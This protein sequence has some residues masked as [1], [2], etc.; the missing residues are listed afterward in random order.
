MKLTN[1]IKTTRFKTTLWYSSIFLLL[2]IVIG[3]VIYFYVETSMSRHLDISLQKQVDLIYHFVSE[4]VVDLNDF[5]AD[6]IYSTS[7]ELVYDLIF[8]AVAFNPTNTFIQVRFKDKVVFK[9]ANLAQSE[10]NISPSNKDEIELFT[11]SDSLLS[12]HPIRAAYLNKNGYK[13]IAAFPIYLINETLGSLTDLYIIIAP[14]FFLLSLVGGALISFRALSRMDRIIKKTNEITAQNLNEIIEGGDFDD[15]YGRLV[16]T[17][18]KMVKRIKTSIDYMNQFSIAAAHELKTPLTI[19]RGEI[20]L[21]LK[22]E[23]TPEQY[24]SVLQSN[25]EE[26]LRLI[27]IIEQLFL[28]TRLDN[29]LIKIQKEPVELKPIIENVIKAFSPIIKS[30][31][32]I[33]DLKCELD[34][35]FVVYVDP[36]LFRQVLINLIDNALKYGKEN[37]DIAIACNKS[38][39]D[40][41]VIIF[42]NI[43]EPIPPEVLSKLFE[44]FYRTESSRN[45]NLGGLGLGLSLVKSIIDLHHGKCFIECSEE[46]KFTFTLNI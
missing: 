45:R 33:L 10:I 37:Y 12:R 1:Y 16:K 22:S 11:F 39:E 40:K 26:T 46:G 27:K 9:T 32:V 20:E 18:N 43:T 44:R 25:Y 23:K 19:L 42:S 30:K 3:I 36:N 17:M 35:E 38:I 28:L 34:D 31:K 8:E 15:E 4:S 5:K 2:E 41:A 13:I 14:I 24:K 21:A 6:S 29:S 7:D